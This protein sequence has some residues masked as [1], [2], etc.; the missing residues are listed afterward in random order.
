[1][2][3]NPIKRKTFQWLDEQGGLEWV[4]DQVASGTHLTA[5]GRMVPAEASGKTQAFKK[6][7]ECLVCGKRFCADG[8]SR[9]LMWKYV[10]RGGERRIQGKQ[11]A[12]DWAVK[13]YQEA[14][15]FSAS[16]LVEQAQDVVD[17]ADGRD[18][19]TSVVHAAATKA[20]MMQWRATKMDRDTWGE[21][22]ATVNLNFGDIH[23][24]AM[25]E[26][27]GPRKEL[28]AAEVP[29]ADFEVVESDEETTES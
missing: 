2:P 3:G 10:S 20:K 18:G 13:A 23:L 5:I 14:V 4:L 21:Q 8:V 12:Q 24:G 27:G 17:A 1:M 16:A 7:Q 29:E 22:P 19:M 25:R 6:P 15:K 26:L 28:P 9:S 11:D